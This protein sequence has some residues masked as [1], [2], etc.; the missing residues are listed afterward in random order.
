MLPPNPLLQLTL[1]RAHSA[2][3]RL[4]DRIW[5]PVD[6]AS[7][8]FGGSFEEHVPQAEAMAL[9]FHEIQL[10][11]AWGK[12]FDQAWFE[13][14]WLPQGRPTYLNWDEQGEATFYVD[15]I[16]YYGFDVAHRHCALPEGQTRGRIESL[17]LQKR[18]LASRRNRSRPPRKLRSIRLALPA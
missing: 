4:Q 16:P 9:D 12:L 8:R 10:P 3:K 2:L 13:I 18:D 17:C 7:V 5:T 15:D 14:E 11:F 6:T 1:P